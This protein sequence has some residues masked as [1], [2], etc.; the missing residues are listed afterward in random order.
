MLYTKL[1]AEFSG[2]AAKLIGEAL[3]KSE[4]GTNDGG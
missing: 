1:K 2:T 3:R 4:A